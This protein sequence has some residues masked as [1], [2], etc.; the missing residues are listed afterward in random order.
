MKRFL[1]GVLS[2]GAL[3]VATPARAAGLVWDATQQEHRATPGE[4]KADFVFMVHNP[5]AAPVVVT[6]VRTSCG[7]TVAGFPHL[8]WTIPAGGSSALQ[9]TVD[10]H[11]KWGEIEKSIFVAVAGGVTTLTVK[12]DAGR[13]PPLDTAL[14]MARAANIQVASVD[15]QAVFT[16]HACAACHAE[17]LAGK[18]GEPLYQ[19]ACGICH[20]SPHRAT[21]VPDLHALAVVPDRAALRAIIARGK[22]G[23]LMPAFSRAQQGPLSDAQIDS[24]VDYLSRTLRPARGAAANARFSRQA[25]SSG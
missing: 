12:V 9:A 7:C 13:Q 18:S 16:N 19:A 17:P 21:M 15:R 3:A 5:S 24:V 1:L 8:P 2:C 14:L 20:E 6:A 4:T 23:S 25:P 11:G 10:F 22:E